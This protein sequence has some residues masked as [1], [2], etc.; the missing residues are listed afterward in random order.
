[1][2]LTLLLRKY[3]KFFKAKIG[4]TLFNYN[5][6]MILATLIEKFQL[7]TGSYI[8]FDR[9]LNWNKINTY[10]PSANGIKWDWDFVLLDGELL[11]ESLSSMDPRSSFS[12]SL[13]SHIFCFNCCICKSNL[14][15]NFNTNWD[16]SVHWK[17]SQAPLLRLNLVSW[18]RE[19]TYKNK[20][21]P[22]CS[23]LSPILALSG[24]ERDYQEKNI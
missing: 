6:S 2:R 14:S 15:A 9:Y 10:L 24:Y 19:T 20:F 12:T 11:W 22:W 17:A 8:F 4:A 7:K 1:M 18:L 23:W 3:F 13:P 5:G 16:A 21:K